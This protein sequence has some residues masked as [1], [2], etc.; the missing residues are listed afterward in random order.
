MTLDN[1]LRFSFL[2]AQLIRSALRRNG[3]V[4]EQA[5]TRMENIL[6]KLPACSI[7]PTIE[8]KKIRE[9][10]FTTHAHALA[11]CKSLTLKGEINETN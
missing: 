11:A 4:P 6:L 2:D 1:Q 9:F 10:I 7:N 8:E 3:I 5:L